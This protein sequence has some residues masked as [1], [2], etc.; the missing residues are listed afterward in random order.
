MTWDEAKSH[1][2]RYLSDKTDNKNLLEYEYPYEFLNKI[3][4]GC[5][6]KVINKNKTEYVNKEGNWV[7]ELDL[8]NK[9]FWV[10]YSLVWAVFENIYT[11]KY[12]DIQG[13]IKSWLYDTFKLRD[14][15]PRLALPPP[16]TRLY[17]TF[18]LRDITPKCSFNNTISPLYDTFK[19]RDITPHW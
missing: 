18:K 10:K 15:T 4:S 2:I 6:E 13:I 19:L 14:I 7:F 1:I 8:K 16:V 5:T 17:D 9:Y 12:S 11:L 3:F